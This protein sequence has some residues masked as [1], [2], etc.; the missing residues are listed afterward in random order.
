MFNWFDEFKASVEVGIKSGIEAGFKEIADSFKKGIGEWFQVPE[1]AELFKLI[2]TLHPTTDQTIA[3]D[4]I[5]VEQNS[6]KVEAYGEK[7]CLLF[8]IAEPNVSE[9]LLLCQAQVKSASLYKPAKLTLS[10]KNSAGWSY[11]QHGAVEGTITWH[12]CKVPFHY[13]KER[14]SGSISV[15]VEFE[16]GGVFWLKDV[17]ILQA[18]VKPPAK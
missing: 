15:S 4:N 1:A 11:Y 5:T 14:F 2:R 8:E 10:I 6:W 9:C 17:E 16:S 3:Q 7:K 13:K 12:L 18:A